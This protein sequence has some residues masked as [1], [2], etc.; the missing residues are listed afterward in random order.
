MGNFSAL[1]GSITQLSWA[2]CS[3]KWRVTNDSSIL[4][5]LE[6]FKVTTHSEPGIS[7]P[8]KLNVLICFQQRKQKWDEDMMNTLGEIYVIKIQFACPKARSLRCRQRLYWSWFEFRN[9]FW[10]FSVHFC[11]S[12]VVTLQSVLSTLP[13]RRR[14]LSQA[15]FL[16]H[17]EHV[18]NFKHMARW[19]L[20]NKIMK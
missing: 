7:Q 10:K 11:D 17:L 18:L 1:L 12:S 3:P 16:E 9:F 13:L 6:W 14:V 15:Y 19:V 5:W 8:H 20:L 2:E 4:I